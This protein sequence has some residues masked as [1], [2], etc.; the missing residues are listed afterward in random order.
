MDCCQ[1]NCGVLDDIR[2]Q[3]QVANAEITR[4]QEEQK[5]YADV[6]QKKS[7]RIAQLEKVVVAVRT[8]T[9]NPKYVVEACKILCPAN[10]K[11]L[12][13]ALKELGEDPD[14]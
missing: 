7:A 5:F 11:R 13:E 9:C 6:I 14:G 1:M 8:M 2:E 3:L 10:Q 12:C 4:L